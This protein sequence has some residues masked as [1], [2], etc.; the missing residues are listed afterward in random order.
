PLFKWKLSWI[1][2]YDILIPM[3]KHEEFELGIK[4]IH[5][6]IRAESATYHIRLD[7]IWSSRGLVTDFAG[8]QHLNVL[9]EWANGTKSPPDLVVVGFGLWTFLRNYERKHAIL[10]GYTKV[11]QEWYDMA[12]VLQ[13]MKNK[14]NVLVWTQTRHRDIGNYNCV[15]L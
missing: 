1:T 11:L 10:A 6:S 7:Y 13:V 9:H 3:K 15:Y 12:E 14:T 4:K 2:P 8:E 5:A